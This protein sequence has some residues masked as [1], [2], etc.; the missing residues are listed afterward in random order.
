MSRAWP[1]I[2]HAGPGDAE[3]PVDDVIH[4]C[5]RERIT[6]LVAHHIEQIVI[7]VVAHFILDV[8]ALRPIDDAALLDPIEHGLSRFRAI[9]FNVSSVGRDCAEMLFQRVVEGNGVGVTANILGHVVVARPD[10]LLARL[11]HDVQEFK[12]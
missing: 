10:D 12:L 5:R 1:S 11:L 3:Q 8:I 7:Q 2:R 6:L 4:H 9:G